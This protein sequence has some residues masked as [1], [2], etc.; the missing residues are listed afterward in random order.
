[1]GAAFEREDATVSK[2]VI[3]TADAPSAIGTYSQAVRAGDWVFLSG[4]I[5]LDPATGALVEGGFEAEARRAFTNLGAV[6][7]AG[8][9]G[10]DSI[11]KLTLYL[12]DLGDF[13]AVNE[14]MQEF[15]SAPYPA[16]AAVGVSSLPRGACMEVEA[17]MMTGEEVTR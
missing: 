13:A 17:I 11:V 12:T 16:R 5:G 8:G 14:L 2:D 3:S 4:Q 15:F 1:M 9:G 10:L 7:A 6:A